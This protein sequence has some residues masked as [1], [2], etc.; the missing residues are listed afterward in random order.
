MA[1]EKIVLRNVTEAR[2]GNQ[3]VYNFTLDAETWLRIGINLHFGEHPLGVNN[4]ISLRH[5]KT[6]KDYMVGR[7]DATM[8]D[9]ITLDLNWD[10]EVEGW[11]FDPVEGTL[12]GTVEADAK[13]RLDGCF[14]INDDGQHRFIACELLPGEER[15]QWQF[16]ATATM[17]AP[18]KQRME[19][20]RQQTRERRKDKRLLLSMDHA[21]AEFKNRA[22]E[23]AYAAALALNT[24]SRSPLAGK[25][26]FDQGKVPK[27]MIN[28]MSLMPALRQ[29]MG[30]N[31][32]I[33]RLPSASEQV[34]VIVDFFAA[35]AQQWSTQWGRQGR[36]LGQ[37]RGFIT[38]L[39][40]LAKGGRFHLALKDD[41]SPENLKRVLGFAGGFKWQSFVGP[42]HNYNT[43]AAALD[44]YIGRHE[45]ESR[46]D[47]GN[48]HADEPAVVDN[49]ES[50]EAIRPSP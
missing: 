5:A 48:G 7:P 50:G 17:R 13:K 27:N 31:S 29:V 30:R 41:Y 24:E 26:F 33:Y 11:V 15:R 37:N 47:N 34:R 36:V 22:T 43:I 8:T 49:R 10:D 14:A 40:F 35:A 28:L 12:T 23:L 38:L 21:R 42:E 9:N 46:T 18:T 6:I 16:A 45:V 44:E 19:R 32:M 4:D 2:Q 39:V 3:V 1:L 20:Y 25:I